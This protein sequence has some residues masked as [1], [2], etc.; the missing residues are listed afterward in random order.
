[1]QMQ[2]SRGLFVWDDE[3][4]PCLRKR[5]TTTPEQL[6]ENTQLLAGRRHETAS[7]RPTLQGLQPLEPHPGATDPPNKG[8]TPRR[9]VRCQV[10]RHGRNFPTAFPDKLLGACV[11]GKVRLANRAA[12]NPTAFRLWVLAALGMGR[13]EGGVVFLEGLN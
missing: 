9:H 10:I 5:R 2:F 11:I 8:T 1:M 13:K 4:G 6:A 3:K 7:T 12:V